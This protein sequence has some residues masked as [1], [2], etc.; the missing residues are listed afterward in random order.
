MINSIL[1][2]VAFT[3][4][5]MFFKYYKKNF[6]MILSLVCMLI[7]V[8]FSLLSVY[9]R[10][11]KLPFISITEGN[12]VSVSNDGAF[13]ITSGASSQLSTSF[14]V[15]DSTSVDE[16]A[17]FLQGTRKNTFISIKSG[18][19][20]LYN[21]NLGVCDEDEASNIIS[22]YKTWKETEQIKEETKRYHFL[23]FYIDV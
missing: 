23:I 13:Y 16:V 5:A 21:S 14:I 18:S 7:L 12:Y 3:V 9:G 20:T 1:G 15:T 11:D 17:K 10:A 2:I 6:F 4:I 8:A 22:I 19:T